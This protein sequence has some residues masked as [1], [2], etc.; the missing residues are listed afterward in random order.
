[1]FQLVLDLISSAGRI[2]AWF[3]I[4]IKSVLNT[5]NIL[6]VCMVITHGKGKDQPG[7]VANPTCGQLNREHDFSLVPFAPENLV[8]R[9]GFGGPV[10]CQPAHLH[11]QAESGTYS[12]DS[13]R[14][15]R[16]RP[17][18]YDLKPPYAIGSVPNSSGHAV[19][20]LCRSLPRVR[21]HRASKPKGSSTR[22]LPWQVIMNQ[23]ICLSLS[24]AH[25]CYDVD[26]FKVPVDGPKQLF[27]GET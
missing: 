7:K 15:P 26:M 12:R 13:S 23:L 24:H 27:G 21:R 4:L 11:T 20:Y 17:F 14:V 16:R 5:M 1:M 19:A 6:Y 25:Y 22:V 18:I 9:N 3:R 2:E 8:S 10:P